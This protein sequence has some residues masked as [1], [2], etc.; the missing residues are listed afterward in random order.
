[1]NIRIVWSTSTFDSVEDLIEIGF[2]PDVRENTLVSPSNWSS[3]LS[4]TWN[5]PTL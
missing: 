1:M 5:S 4:R 3:N 2:P